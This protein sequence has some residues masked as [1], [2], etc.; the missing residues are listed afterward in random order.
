MIAVEFHPAADEELVEATE[1]YA[2]RSAKAAAGFVREIEHAVARIA[3]RRRSDTLSRD[4]A[5]GVLC[6]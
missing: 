4:S 5:G 3:R 1:W 6:C 2:R